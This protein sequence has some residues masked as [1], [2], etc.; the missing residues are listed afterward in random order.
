M[1]KVSYCFSTSLVFKKENQQNMLYLISTLTLLKELKT[2][3]TACIFLNFAKA[4]DTVNHEILPRKLHHYDM[5]EI[6]LEY[7][8]SYLMNRLQVVKL[9]QHL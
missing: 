6:A 3:K 2:T 4:F 5:R 7:F 1:M 9:G 8:Q